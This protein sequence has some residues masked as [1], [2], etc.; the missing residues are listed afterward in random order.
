[1]EVKAAFPDAVSRAT[2]RV[3]IDKHT[4]RFDRDAAQAL[5]ALGDVSDDC[6]CAPRRSLKC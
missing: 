6:T 2:R 3:D 4:H 5:A 1:M